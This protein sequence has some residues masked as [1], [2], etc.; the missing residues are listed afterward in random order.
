MSMMFCPMLRPRWPRETNKCATYYSCPRTQLNVS[1][2]HF[3]PTSATQNPSPSSFKPI[4]NQ[5]KPCAGIAGNLEEANGDESKNPCFRKTPSNEVL[6][7]LRISGK[8]STL[9][10]RYDTSG[11]AGATE[12]AIET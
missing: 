10:F 12:P 3:P 1:P 9:A 8:S 2:A 5:G 6:M 7:R 4:S 11:N